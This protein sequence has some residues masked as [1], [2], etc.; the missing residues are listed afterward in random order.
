MFD[1]LAKICTQ[2]I[3]LGGENW[4]DIA[5]AFGLGGIT[6]ALDPRMA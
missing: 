6:S 2:V 3:T 1:L 5:I 4:M